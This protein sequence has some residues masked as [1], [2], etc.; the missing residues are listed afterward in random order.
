MPLSFPSTGKLEGT[1]IV[2]RTSKMVS[3][4]MKWGTHPGVIGNLWPLLSTLKLTLLGGN[5]PSRKRYFWKG[6]VPLWCLTAY[7]STHSFQWELLQQ[8]LSTQAIV[9]KHQLWCWSWHNLV[10]CTLT[11]VARFC[12]FMSVYPVWLPPWLY[13]GP[14]PLSKVLKR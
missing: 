2:P 6:S 11:W 10:C 13:C 9:L 8:W 12:S 4:F 1:T 14:G 5:L 3:R 7:I